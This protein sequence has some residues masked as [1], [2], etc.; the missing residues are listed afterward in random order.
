[1]EEQKSKKKFW[2]KEKLLFT[3]GVVGGFSI[4]VGIYCVGR[5][6]GYREHEKL[7]NEGLRKMFEENPG[8]EKMM[9]VAL[10]DPKDWYEVIEEMC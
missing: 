3:T 5:V 7:T 8:F 4:G 9:S 10:T 1:M 6:S 2:T